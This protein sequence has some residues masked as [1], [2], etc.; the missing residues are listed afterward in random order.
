MYL[1]ILHSPSDELYRELIL[2]LWSAA[3]ALEDQHELLSLAD[4]EIGELKEE[5]ARLKKRETKRSE[6]HKR[7]LKERDGWEQRAIEQACRISDAEKTIASQAASLTA[8]GDSVSAVEAQRRALVLQLATANARIT[9]GNQ[10]MDSSATTISAREEEL[11]TANAQLTAV[12]A[13]LTTAL[14]AITTAHAGIAQRDDQL[15]RQA[16]LHAQ[17][18]HQQQNLH[19]QT[20]ATTA[21]A[22]RDAATQATAEIQTLRRQLSE[23]RTAAI[24]AESSAVTAIAAAAAAN[25]QQ[26]QQTPPAVITSDAATQSEAATECSTS[27]E[28]LLRQQVRGLRQQVEELGEWKARASAHGQQLEEHNRQLVA[29]VAQADSAGLQLQRDVESLRTA[30]DASTTVTANTATTTTATIT[31]AATATADDED[32]MPPPALFHA[33]IREMERQ[34]G[35]VFRAHAG[36]GRVRK[37]ARSLENKLRIVHG[38]YRLCLR[39]VVASAAQRRRSRA[40]SAFAT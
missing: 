18:Q 30:L 21:Q 20:V 19:Q 5:V 29:W 25:A 17:Q 14:V 36:M 39:D 33:R 11:R 13:R 34:E 35:A 1:T 2:R 7:V 31:T 40:L 15:Q 23:A 4:T 8:A 37:K 24:A 3:G 32:V 26:Q 10:Q 9:L 22:S 38:Q 16:V 27:D 6:E 12:N 28:A